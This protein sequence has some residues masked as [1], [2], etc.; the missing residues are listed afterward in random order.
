MTEQRVEA[1]ERALSILEAFSENG[2]RLTLAELAEETGLYKSTILRLSA[3]LER[4]GY[5][6]RSSDGLFR[7]GPS[8][9][10]LGSIYRRTF[11]VGEHIRPELRALVDA[12]GE[13]ASFYVRENNERVCLYRENS[14]QAVRYHLDEGSR[15]P[16]DKGAAA[17][18][19]MAFSD[20]AGPD[21]IEVRK[22]GYAISRGERNSDVAAASVP[23]LNARNRLC[24]A[25]AVSGPINRFG[26]AAHDAALKRLKISAAKLHQIL[27]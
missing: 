22:R 1:V 18:I 14:P 12:T 20:D 9:W 19:L 25:L 24:G 4:Y 3:S 8:L 15:L 26:D 5:L 6:I 7:I 13:T 17:H 16:I 21:D 11:N 23:I 27:T 2:D 10:R